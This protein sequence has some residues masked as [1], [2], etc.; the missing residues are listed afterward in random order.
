MAKSRRELKNDLTRKQILS[1]A[2]TLFSENGYDN[3]SMDDIAAIANLAKGTL[4]YHFDSKE[5]VVVA[6]RIDSFIDT[7]QNALA[8]LNKSSKVIPILE[9]VFLER[10]AWTEKNPEL[11]KVFFE[12]R[13][14][15]FLFRE[16][17]SLAVAEVSHAA[18]LS[19]AL[20]QRII[21]INDELDPKPDTSRF[22][23][24]IR[25]LIVL[26]QNNNELRS[27]LDA[28]EIAQIILATFIHAQG[29]WIGGYSST[30]LVDKMHRWLHAILDGLYV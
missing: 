5:S 10:A 6:L 25:D 24:L 28:T 27:D 2:L 7:L 29:S 17:T 20:P 9:K 19:S 30:S 15:Q 21:N 12:Q 23:A 26:G 11:A 4:Y 16:D 13:I 22:Y 3:T 1:A 14:H 18:K 8:D